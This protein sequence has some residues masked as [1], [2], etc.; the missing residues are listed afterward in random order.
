VGAATDQ[1]TAEVAVPLNDAANC[2]WPPMVA[3]A[4][5]GVTVNEGE[6]YLAVTV[7]L[8][9]I[10]TVQVTVVEEAHPLHEAKVLLPEVAGAVSVTDVPA[11]YVRVKLVLPLVALLLSAGVTVTATPLAGLVEFTVRT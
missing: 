5:L 11:L 3:V 8:A 1:V 4:G 9:L 7:V 2:N 6:V 10:D